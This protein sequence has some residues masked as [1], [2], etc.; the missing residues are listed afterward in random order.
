MLHHLKHT[1]PDCAFAIH[2]CVIYTFKPNEFPE[3]G[4]KCIV[5]YW[6]DTMDK[7][8]ILYPN[9]DPMIDCY[10]DADFAG[11]WGHEHPQYQH[12]VCSHT[13]YVITLADCPIVYVS[14]L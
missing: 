7:C 9:D 14:R 8:I 4:I 10:P 12:C 13:C 11:L 2:Q 1:Q 3:A 6:K 5:C